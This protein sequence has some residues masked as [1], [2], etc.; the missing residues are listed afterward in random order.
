MSPV[1]WNINAKYEFNHDDGDGG[2]AAL[3][4]K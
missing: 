2:G 4:D 3:S 1:D